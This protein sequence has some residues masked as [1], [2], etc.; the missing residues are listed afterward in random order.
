MKQAGLKVLGAVVVMG[1]LVAGAQ[2]QS[3][4]LGAGSY[5]M[6]QGAAAAQADVAAKDDLFAGTEVFAKNASDVNE[7]TMD[8]DT[9]ADV[10]GPN[11]HKAHNMVLN[12][13]RSYTFD[14]PGMYNMADVDAIRAKLNTGDWHCSVHTRDLKTGESSD[15]CNKRR[16][17][18]LRETAII[19]VEPKELTFIHTITRRSDDDTSEMGAMPMIFGPG[20]YTSLAMLD[21]EQ[22]VAMQTA[23]AKL[24]AIEM[25]KMRLNMTLQMDKSQQ[26]VEM[27]D[28]S[29]AE[30]YRQFETYGEKY[31]DQQK[32]K[33]DQDKAKQ[34]LDTAKD[35]DKTL[36]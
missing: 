6:M 13:V 15:I 35:K 32:L 20:N 25:P 31:K 26:A 12:V 8:P 19:T 7:I 16:T 17:D 34:N 23:M 28:R 21:P 22:F 10:G 18:G 11:R 2:A 9:L 5:S 27:L 4:A 14:K 3:V 33:D 24:N 29:R 1:W 36:Q 30:Q